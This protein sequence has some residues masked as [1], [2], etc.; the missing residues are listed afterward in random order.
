MGLDGFRRWSIG[1]ASDSL[2]LPD[3][4][5]LPTRPYESVVPIE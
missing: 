5:L 4:V 2:K 1:P 3:S